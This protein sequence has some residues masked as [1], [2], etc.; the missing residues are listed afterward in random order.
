MAVLC[1]YKTWILE[2]SFVVD[3]HIDAKGSLCNI[4]L[5]MF[6]SIFEVPEAVYVSSEI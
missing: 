6:L 5:K 1:F 3:S 4:S 2:L